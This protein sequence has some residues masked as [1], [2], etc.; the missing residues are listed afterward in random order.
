MS[1]FTVPARMQNFLTS[2]FFCHEKARS[3][4]GKIQVALD[5]SEKTY[6][7]GVAVHKFRN[8]SGILPLLF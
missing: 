3:I 6:Y 7:N 1:T 2:L 5:F 8:A 4:P